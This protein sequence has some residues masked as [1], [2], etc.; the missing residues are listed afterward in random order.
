MPSSTA[1]SKQQSSS[2]DAFT[3]VDELVSKPVLGSDGA[4][5][6]VKNTDVGGISTS[7]RKLM[8]IGP[9]SITLSFICLKF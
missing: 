1:P 5:S 9:S 6:Y 4:A 2:Y 8:A 3:K 7:I